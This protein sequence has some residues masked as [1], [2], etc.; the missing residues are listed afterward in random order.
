MDN[1]KS[2]L[3]V[4]SLGML[5][6]LN[7]SSAIDVDASV[8]TVR[9]SCQEGG[10]NLD[11]CFTTMEAA[12]TWMNNTRNPQPGVAAPLLVDVGPGTFNSF[13]CSGFSHITVRG[14]GQD[15]TV[16]TDTTGLGS[17]LSFQCDNMLFQDFT[18][19]NR[20]YWLGNKHTSMWR[21]I[22]I[23]GTSQGSWYDA[24]GT[25][26]WFSSRIT[27]NGGVGYVSNGPAENW[28]FG[29]EIAVTGPGGSTAAFTALHMPN[30]AEAHVYGSTI[31]V[32]LEDG[33][34]IP[35]GGEGMTAV[36]AEAG[37]EIHIHGTGIDVIGNALGNDITA[38]YSNGG[39]IH[40]NESSYVMQTGA[41]G[42]KRRIVNNGGDV[43][44]PYLWQ[45][46]AEPPAIVSQHGA[47]MAVT[48][49][50]PDGQPHLVVN[51]SNCASGW[52]DLATNLC[53]P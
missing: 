38:L 45:E 49:N 31:R 24:G 22:T 21:N 42:V 36:R 12:L 8:V 27:S 9:S 10:N 5:L 15:I 19:N 16:I 50:N 14:S 20:G 51:S 1:I 28:F 25:H 35:P 7:A 32:E 2:V 30:G 47:D 37:G 4:F 18:M 41:G 43:R 3:V 29:T 23:L 39:M 53:R 44:A 11:N 48:T 52:F 17:V 40:A 33:A 13:I 34:T 26:Y 6:S 46:G